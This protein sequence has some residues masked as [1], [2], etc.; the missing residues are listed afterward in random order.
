[1]DSLELFFILQTDRIKAKPPV[2]APGPKRPSLSQ[3][4]MGISK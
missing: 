2:H 3:Q 4:E 1:M